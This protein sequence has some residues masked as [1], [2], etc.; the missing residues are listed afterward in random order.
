MTVRTWIGWDFFLFA[1]WGRFGERMK[2]RMKWIEEKEQKKTESEIGYRGIEKA[3][4]R[5]CSAQRRDSSR[6]ARYLR[7]TKRVWNEREYAWPD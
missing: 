6:P 2:K 7:K 4:V 5:D 1:G 3:M